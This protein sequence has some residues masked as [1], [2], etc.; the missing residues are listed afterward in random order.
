[1]FL[2]LFVGLRPAGLQALIVAQ[3]E[4]KESPEIAARDINGLRDRNLTSLEAR[5]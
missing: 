2:V 1:M 5:S 4:A 3:H